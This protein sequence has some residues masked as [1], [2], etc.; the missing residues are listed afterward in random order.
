MRKGDKNEWKNILSSEQIIKINNKIPEEWF[1]N[2]NW[3]I[4][5]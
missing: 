3:D 1:K 4:N 2:Y 5:A